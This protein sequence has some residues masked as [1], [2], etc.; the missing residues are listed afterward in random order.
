MNPQRQET[1]LHGAKK[2]DVWVDT[3]ETLDLKIAAQKSTQP[4]G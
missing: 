1:L 4:A 3:S 2:P